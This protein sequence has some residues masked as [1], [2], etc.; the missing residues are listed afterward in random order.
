VLLVQR[1]RQ[2]SLMPGMWELPEVK[3]L[4]STEE[5]LFSVKHSITI[6]DFTVHVVSGEFE[7]HSNKHSRG[8]WVKISRLGKLPLTGLTRKILRRAEII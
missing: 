5:R 3:S 1:D 7:N 8:T 6:T 4:V 2:H